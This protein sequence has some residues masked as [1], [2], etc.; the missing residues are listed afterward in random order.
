MHNHVVFFLFTT[1]VYAIGRSGLHFPFKLEHASLYARVAWWLTH[2]FP[3]IMCDSC[4]V[5]L[6]WIWP[7]STLAAALVLVWT[8]IPNRFTT[9]QRW[10]RLRVAGDWVWQIHQR[11]TLSISTL[12][13]SYRRGLYQENWF[14]EQAPKYLFAFTDEK[15][16]SGHNLSSIPPRMGIQWPPIS[17]LGLWWHAEAG[18]ARPKLLCPEPLTIISCIR[19]TVE[20]PNIL[21]PVP[22]LDIR[23]IIRWETRKTMVNPLWECFPPTKHHQCYRWTQCESEARTYWPY[24]LAGRVLI[25]HVTKSG[26]LIA[27]GKTA[28]VRNSSYT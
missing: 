20:W 28:L 13:N 3:T 19:K 15:P 23:R 6:L 10:Q 11:P 22:R 24:V 25:M 8:L 5:N 26:C 18:V 14:L 17:I 1:P 7:S 16:F 4:V 21:L 27:R 2:W 12:C 9:T